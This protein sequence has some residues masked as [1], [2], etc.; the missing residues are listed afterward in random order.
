MNAKTGIAFS[1]HTLGCKVNQYE[2]ERIAAELGAY[3]WEMV[4]FSS[5]AD[6]Y[7]INS[8][9]VTAVAGHKSRQLI[10]R[11]VRN[12]P[13]ARV[14]VTGCYADS[15]RVAIEAIEGVS[16][17]LGNDDKDRLPLLVA[18]ELGI[19]I[20]PGRR[21]PGEP[22]PNTTLHTRALVKIQDGCDQFCSYC[23]VPHVRGDLWS[24]PE[25]EIVD[26]VARLAREGTPEIV[27]TGIHL[28][29][30]G[31][32][33]DTGLADL[34]AKLVEI[35]GLGR[36]RL[37]SIELREVTPELVDLIAASPKLCKHLHIP[38]QNG[39]NA[40]LVAM[41][42]HY[43]AEEF[44]ERA[45][46]LT[47]SIEDIALTTDIIV[48]FPSETDADFK[49]TM[50]LV[51]SIGFSRLHVFKFSPRK[52]T[53]AAGLGGQIPKDVKEKRSAELIALGEDLAARFA[54]R[55]IGKELIVSIERRQGEHLSGMSDNYI[56]VMCAGSDELLGRLARV[57]IEKQEDATLYGRVVGARE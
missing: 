45:H 14:V 26:E 16:L 6:V 48:G 49:S 23:I 21:T 17:V 20:E 42:R 18:Q 2:S 33:Q 11:A 9:T 19:G 3:G 38:L 56:R 31:A 5:R 13:G 34:L 35:E 25:P 4:A 40:V 54:S 32:G 57:R 1:I 29:L 27:L 28:G 52:G 43:S 55:Y 53:P 46:Y 7:I 8:C 22:A 37:S 50:D 10:R 41:N 30:Y 47:S 36:I 15:D 24:R 51:A 39:S 12:N 44:A